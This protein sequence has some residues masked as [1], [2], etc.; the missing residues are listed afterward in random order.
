MIK[1]PPAV[2]YEDLLAQEEDVSSALW[3]VVGLPPIAPYPGAVETFTSSVEDLMILRRSLK[4]QSG[5]GD[6]GKVAERSFGT[7]AE[8]FPEGVHLE[9]GGEEPGEEE[10]TSP[11]RRRLIVGDALSR[12]SS[13]IQ[14][15]A[16]PEECKARVQ[17][18]E[19]REQCSQE[20]QR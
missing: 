10:K 6:E 20:L 11:L 3:A 19:E 18:C 16:F 13:A 5:S 17:S 2:R 8:D 4:A 9:R 12:A 7:F 14:D 15:R 1:T